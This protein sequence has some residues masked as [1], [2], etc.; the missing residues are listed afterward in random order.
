MTFIEHYSKWLARAAHG[1]IGQK[2]KYSG[3]RYT[4]HTEAVHAIVMRYGGTPY[5]GA[6]AFLHDTFEDYVTK[7]K[8]EKRWIAL[9]VFLFLFWLLPRQVKQLVH[10][11]T[12]V[13]TSENYPVKQNPQWNR[14][15]RKHQ[16]AARIAKISDAAKEVKLSD[17]FDN[18]SS[19]VNEDADFAITYLKEKHHMM[20]GLHGYHVNRD[21][22]HLVENQ[23]KQ[24]IDKLKV[25][26]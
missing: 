7:V 20:K 10:E 21:L 25:I 4:I 19:I 22:Y 8:A 26:V 15:W 17:L 13:Y 14:K 12:D 9:Y 23:L 3:V 18:T 6:A 1:Y 11:L 16:E 5:Q 24:N 2:R